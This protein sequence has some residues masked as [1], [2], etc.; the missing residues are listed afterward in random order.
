M[1]RNNKALS[2]FNVYCYE[3]LDKPPSLSLIYVFI[4]FTDKI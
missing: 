2:I 4:F 3:I 1:L